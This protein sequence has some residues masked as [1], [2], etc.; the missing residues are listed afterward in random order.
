MASVAG[1]NAASHRFVLPELRYRLPGRQHQLYARVCPEPGAPRP[2]AR[3]ERTV[4][5]AHRRGVGTPVSHRVGPGGLHGGAGR[6]ALARGRAGAN[7]LRRRTASGPGAVGGGAPGV[8]AHI[9]A[10]GVDCRYRP[11]PPPDRATSGRDGAH[12]RCARVGGKRW[13]FPGVIVSPPGAPAQCWPRRH[14]AT[15]ARIRR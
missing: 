6:P 9:V 1:V 14:P 12:S 11:G 8:A 4:E 10:P 7:N 5:P 15:T 3:A 2:D 13:S